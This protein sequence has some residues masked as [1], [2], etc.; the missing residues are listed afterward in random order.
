M[1]STFKSAKV[2]RISNSKR[3]KCKD[4]CHCCPFLPVF[5]PLCV[6]NVFDVFVFFSNLSIFHPSMFLF[7]HEELTHAQAGCKV[8]SKT[9]LEVDFQTLRSLIGPSSFLWVV[10]FSPLGWCCAFFAPPLKWCC[11]SYLVWV[12][13]RFLILLSGRAC[14]FPL[15]S[16]FLPLLLSGRVAVPL[17]LQGGA[18]F[19]PPSLGWKGKEAPLQRMMGENITHP[20]KEEG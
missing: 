16:P 13:L 9:H 19:P 18:A 12:V 5:V 3:P 20:K 4:N 10:Q 1:S 8:V 2:P 15:P 7:L 14:R 17:L 11:L 6:P